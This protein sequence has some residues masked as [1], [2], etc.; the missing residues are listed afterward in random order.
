MAVGIV[1]DSSCDLGD[2]ELDG[3]DVQIVPLFIRFGTDDFVDREQI[4]VEDFYRRMAAAEE[5]P[6]TA[7]PP[8]GRFEQAFRRC[9]DAGAEAVVCINLSAAISATMQSAVQ[10]AGAVQAEDGGVDIR[11][12]DSRS[13]TAGL[14]T[15][16][17]QAARM[18]A[19][20]AGA[21][22]IEQFV[23]DASERTHV[24]GTLDTL[25]NLRKGGRIGGAQALLGSMLSIK[26]IVDISSGTV[27]EAAKQRTRR[28]ALGWLRDTLRAAAPVEHLAVMHGE[29]PDVDDFRGMLAEVHSGDI[30]V[31]KVGPVVGT[32][33]GQGVLGMAYQVPAA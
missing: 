4:A 22:D 2:A 8:P 25:E 11:V 30:R 9:L 32:H 15:L 1:T 24:F 31:C 21:D 19:D 17:L 16:V 13:V 27:A 7:A 3:L 20:G 26:P 14:G 12:L 10:A 5:L 23:A 18:A 33:A 6:Q 29:A 28:K